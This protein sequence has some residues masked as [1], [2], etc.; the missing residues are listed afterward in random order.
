M[1]TSSPTGG[2]WQTGAKRSVTARRAN[3]RA[4]LPRRT[5]RRASGPRTSTATRR[6]ANAHAPW[7][8]FRRGE[9]TVLSNV[10]LISEGSTCRTAR[11]R[12]CCGP[13]KSLALYIQQSMRPM[14]YRPGKRAVILD[15]V[16]NYARFGLPDAD[17]TWTLDPKHTKKTGQGPRPCASARSASPPLSRR[18][19]ARCAAT[20]SRREGARWRKSARRRLRRSRGFT[21]CYDS[22]AQCRDYAELRTYGRQ[23]GYKPGLGPGLWQRK[24]VF[25]E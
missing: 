16:G 18:T 24:E 8:R 4:P 3:T 19:S 11:V 20:A 21:L 14:R 5:A 1:A 7:R 6:S 25:Y 9:I 13:T 17:R 12:C 2:V 10:D 15:H 23:K 22:P